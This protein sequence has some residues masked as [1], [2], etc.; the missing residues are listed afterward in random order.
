VTEKT[1]QMLFL[2]KMAPIIISV[3]S[4]IFWKLGLPDFQISGLEEIVRPLRRS[5]LTALDFHIL[6]VGHVKYSIYAMSF[7]DLDRQKQR[8]TS[9]MATIKM[10]MLHCIWMEKEYRLNICRFT[11]C[12]H[13]DTYQGDI[14][15]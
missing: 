10:D 7:C 1:Q 15:L 11:N 8:I 13:L 4:S 9:V 14:K 6:G 12:A 2:I 5:N 3:W